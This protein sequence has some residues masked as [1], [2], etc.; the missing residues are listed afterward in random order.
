MI[1]LAVLA[2]VVAVTVLVWIACTRAA[3]WMRRRAV[4]RQEAPRGIAE[5]ERYLAEQGAG[6]RR[7]RRRA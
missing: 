2:S 1:G 4:V 3:P 7:R 5:L 6:R